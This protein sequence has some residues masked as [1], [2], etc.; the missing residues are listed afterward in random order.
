[1]QARLLAFRQGRIRPATD[2]KVLVSWNALALIAFAEAGRY[3]QRFDFITAAVKNASF[4]LAALHSGDRLLRSWRAESAHH[5]AYLEDYAGLIL[6][7]LALYQSDPQPHWYVAASQLAQE[8][9]DHYTDQTGGFFDTRDDAERLVVRPRDL[10]DNATPSGS[11]LAT[12]ALLQLDAF[13]GKPDWRKQAEA[14][15]GK[16]QGIMLRYP[17]AFSFWL[18]TLDFAIGPV[19]QIA[20]LGNPSQTEMK[21]MLSILWSTFRPNMVAA[22]SAFPPP[23]GSPALLADRPLLQEQPTAYVCEG[24]VCKLPVTSPGEF[25]SQ[26]AAETSPG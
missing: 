23:E 7:L 1:L 12:M 19:R 8:M 14:L 24:F 13:V 5:A 15:L 17:T 21:E 3:L 11:A 16:M 10:Q 4:I 22:T 6:G 9:V 20:L 18:S 25:K 26:L 2:D